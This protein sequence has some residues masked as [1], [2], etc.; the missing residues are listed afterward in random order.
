MAKNPYFRDYSGE[1]NIIEDLSIEIIKAMGRDMLYI[2]REQFNKDIEF[3]EA[4][5]K[6]TKTFPLEMYI[7]S[8]SGFEGEG[9]V[10]SKFGLEVRDKVTLIVSRKR[11]G[12]EVSERYSE[13]TRP[14]EGD[15]IYFPLTKGLFEINFVEHE[16]PFYQVGK[17][18]TYALIC[19]LITLDDDEFDTGDTDIDVVVAENKTSISLFTIGSQITSGKKFYDGELVYQVYGV[20]GGTGGAYTNATAQANCFKYYPSTNT[21][22]VF[23]I[24]GSF[25]YSSQSI[26]GKDS[27]AEFYLTG[28]TSTNI[29]IPIRPTDSQAA[30]DNEDIK[31][32][33]DSINIYDFTDIDPFSEGKY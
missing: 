30:G 1:Q 2:P 26:R 16:N 19:E 22:E 15:L 28:V 21:M 12:Q 27:G 13:I 25:Y 10:I 33:G 31:D 11:F 3:G 5:Y 20:T 32:T 23:G 17:L 8:V 9:D 24:S 6:Y 14:R 29:V 18:Y 4:R 7:A